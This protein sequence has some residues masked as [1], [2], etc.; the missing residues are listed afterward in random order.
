[1]HPHVVFPFITTTMTIVTLTHLTILFWKQLKLEKILLI[2]QWY[3]ICH[4]LI[5]PNLRWNQLWHTNPSILS[6]QGWP[7]KPLK[8]LPGK[9]KVCQTLKMSQEMPSKKRYNNSVCI[10]LNLSPPSLN[11]LH[12]P[13]ICVKSDLSTLKSYLMI[14]CIILFLLTHL[15]IARR[16]NPESLGCHLW[17]KKL[18]SIQN[19]VLL[20]WMG[21]LAGTLEN[22]SQI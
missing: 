6:L 17:P 4:T 12:Q 10:Q 11:R 5:L 20:L 8:F 2:M 9:V 14:L 7:E 21:I 22:P 3:L 13:R 16:R 19:S 1:M 15:R 18:R